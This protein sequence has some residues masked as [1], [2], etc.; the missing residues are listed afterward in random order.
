MSTTSQ[1]IDLELIAKEMKRLLMLGGGF[2]QNFVI[3]KAKSMGYYVLCLDADPDAQG[4]HIADEYAV[5]DIVDEEACLA[6]AL[7][8]NVDGVLT[9]ATDFSVLTMSRIA[10]EMYL[11]GINYNSAK[12]IK[13]K[14]SVRKILFETQADDTGYSYEIDSIEAIK[15][16][17][18]KVKF[19]I[20]MKPVDGSGSRGASKVEK[21]EDFKKAAELAMSDSI[22]HRAVAEPFI[23][24]KEYG[25]ES[26]VDNGVVHVLAV[27]QKEMT[28]PPYYAE[29]GHAI[30]SELGDEM[31]TKVKTCVYRAI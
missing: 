8:K 11:P 26:F 18:S 23:D 20:M 17:L 30:P 25:V 13:N 1:T 28:Q 10:E 7:K 3:K 24:G 5:I 27:M 2:L 29:L 19:P 16:V 21:V 14:A 31:E 9:A 22:T 6:Y 15:E 4:F 12:I